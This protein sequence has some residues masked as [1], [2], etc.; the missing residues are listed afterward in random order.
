MTLKQSLEKRMKEANIDR[1]KLKTIRKNF[2]KRF[3][4]F[5][6]NYDNEKNIISE[7]N[8]IGAKDS[9]NI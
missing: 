7:L 5:K 3:R 9:D 6:D 1:K 4:K 8:R 2:A